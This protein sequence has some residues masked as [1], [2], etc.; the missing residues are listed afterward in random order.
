MAHDIV[1]REDHLQGRLEDAASHYREALR[2]QPL[3]DV[4]LSRMGLVLQELGRTA[5]AVDYFR[6]AIEVN[7]DYPPAHYNLGMTLYRSG[8]R[9]AARREFLILKK[10]GVPQADALLAMVGGPR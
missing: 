7:P 4:T 2:I 9:A 3:Y 5:E 1:G 6:R 10:L 8:D